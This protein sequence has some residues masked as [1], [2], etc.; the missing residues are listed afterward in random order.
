[1]VTE[2]AVRE[3]LGEERKDEETL[4]VTM[5]NLNPN[6][7]DNKGRAISPPTTSRIDVT[8]KVTTIWVHY[9]YIVIL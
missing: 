9:I 4:R 1:M 3:K 6:D 7:S 5:T 2:K 8:D